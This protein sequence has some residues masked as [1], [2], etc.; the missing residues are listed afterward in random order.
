[1]LQKTM[2]FDLKQNHERVH[3]KHF[4]AIVEKNKELH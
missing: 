4:K 2:N 1:M 3:E